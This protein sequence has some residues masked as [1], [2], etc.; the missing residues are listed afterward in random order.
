M[1]IQQIETLNTSPRKLAVLAASLGST[2]GHLRLGT[3]R[4][5]FLSNLALLI[6]MGA[7]PAFANLVQDGSFEL[8]F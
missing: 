5:M 2:L 7:S 1:R 3:Q 8:L 4:R 6:V